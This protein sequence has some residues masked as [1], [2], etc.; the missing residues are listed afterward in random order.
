MK[1][2]QDVERRK[3]GRV[4]GGK[5]GYVGIKKQAMKHIVRAPREK[6]MRCSSR[7]RKKHGEGGA[8]REEKTNVYVIK[9][10]GK[11]K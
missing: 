1:K 10:S 6:K 11:K 5:E 7:S 4:R 9:T 2:K 3:K 8:R